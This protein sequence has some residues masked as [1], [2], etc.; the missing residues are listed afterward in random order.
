[1]RTIEFIDGGRSALGMEKR[2]LRSIPRS[3]IMIIVVSAVSLSAGV[4]FANQGQTI[5][6]NLRRTVAVPPRVERI[7]SLQPEITRILVALGVADRLVGV[8]YFIGRDDY[9][10]KILFPNGTGLPVV[11]MP[12]ESINKELIVRLDP[13]IIF[14][15]PTELQVP[16]SIQRSLGIPVAALAS[17]GSFEGL[18]EEMELIGTLTGREEKARELGRYF[19]EKIRS[20]T[21]FTAP[22]AIKDRPTT[23]LAFWSSLV[24]TPVFYEPVQTA[25]GRNVA[26][27]LLPPRL[28]TIGTVITVEQILKWDPDMILIQGSFL[29]HERQVTVEGVLGDKRLGSVKAI[30][31]GRVHYTLGFWYWWDPAAVLVE[32]L[33]LARLFHPIKFSWLDLEKE[34]NEIYEEFY[35]EPQLFTKLMRFLDFHEWTEK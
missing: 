15:S 7:L 13:D 12:D 20:I 8:D 25:G 30:K 35:R 33:Y 31:Q 17:M 22:L 28:G 14:T 23:Y 32:T 1:M 19:R 5:T 11:S 18:L 6:D 27:N 16:D 10:F 3:L 21:K 26:D 4:L 29:P 34:G 9:L 24:R 2:P